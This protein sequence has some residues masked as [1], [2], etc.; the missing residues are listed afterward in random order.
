MGFARVPSPAPDAS[1]TSSSRGRSS[2]I[3]GTSSR[4]QA[5]MHAWVLPQ[6]VMPGGCHSLFR[7][8]DHYITMGNWANSGALR[9]VFCFQVDNPI[10]SRAPHSAEDR[11]SACACSPMTWR[12][13]DQLKSPKW[14]SPHLWKACTLENAAR[15]SNALLASGASLGP[16]IGQYMG[17]HAWV[18]DAPMQGPAYG[19][20]H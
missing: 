14:P 12:R 17:L 4:Y 16:C 6:I 3:P 15:E 20:V 9:L 2:S 8:R 7:V 19:P 10:F 11:S 5:S 13:A 18:H 1:S